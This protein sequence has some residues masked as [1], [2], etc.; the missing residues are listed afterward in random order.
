MHALAEDFR[1]GHRGRR[2]LGAVVLV[3][4][5]LVFLRGGSGPGT[6]AAEYQQAWDR[7]DWAAVWELSAPELRAGDTQANFVSLK[8]RTRS[9]DLMGVLDRVVVEREETRG[10]SACVVLRL[11][12]RDAGER[13]R[14]VLLRSIDG[15]WRV[16]DPELPA[17]DCPLIL[18]YVVGLSRGDRV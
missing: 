3:A 9:P 14:E 12:L 13:V 7:Q 17:G 15:A 11:Y 16:V 4:M 1:T 18:N 8:E 2:L 5:I 10:D 6:V